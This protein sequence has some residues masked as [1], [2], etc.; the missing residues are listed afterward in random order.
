MWRPY[1]SAG[2]E[3]DISY[4]LSCL[5]R[6]DLKLKPSQEAGIRAVT[7]RRFLMAPD[8]IRKEYLLPSSPLLVQLQARQIDRPTTVCILN[9]YRPHALC[10]CMYRT[11]L[12]LEAKIKHCLREFNTVC[13]RPLFHCPPRGLVPRLGEH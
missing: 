1:Y 12:G 13:P 7:Q 6:S 5:N 9:F 2:F 10:T 4:T 8:W 11:R 3:S